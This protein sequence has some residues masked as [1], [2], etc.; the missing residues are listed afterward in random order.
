[1]RHG[2]VAPDVSKNMSF[3]EQARWAKMTSPGES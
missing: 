2:L 1:M 3:W